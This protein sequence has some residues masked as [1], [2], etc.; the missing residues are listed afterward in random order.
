MI[1]FRHR[2]SQ[3]EG[4]LLVNSAGQLV[5]HAENDA[6]TYWRKGPQTHD[7][8]LSLEPG[9]GALFGTCGSDPGGGEFAGGNLPMNVVI[10]RNLEKERRKE[11][12]R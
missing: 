2:G 4:W 8:I 5:Y 12:G 3:W 7:E 11:N 9:S 6:Y 1:I 10:A